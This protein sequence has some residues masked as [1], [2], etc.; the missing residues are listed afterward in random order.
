MILQSWRMSSASP[1]RYAGRDRFFQA[2]S[3]TTLTDPP[4]NSNTVPIDLDLDNPLLPPPPSPCPAPL[5]LYEDWEPDSRPDFPPLRPPPGLETSSTG[6]GILGSKTGSSHQRGISSFGDRGLSYSRPSRSC[7]PLLSSTT[8]MFSSSSFSGAGSGSVPWPS[9][10]TPPG[11]PPDLRMTHRLSLPAGITGLEGQWQ[12][13]HP[14]HGM[15]NI[16]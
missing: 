12:E 9:L 6:L 10:S 3:L 5:E 13:P 15:W 2:P 7:S 11:F 4:S 16:K 14:F 8:P 1:D